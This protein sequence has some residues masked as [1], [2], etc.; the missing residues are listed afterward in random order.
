MIDSAV[1]QR[2]VKRIEGYEQAMIHLQIGL[3]AIP[4]LAPENGG[5]GGNPQGGISARL[6]AG[7]GISS[8]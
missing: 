2:I 8:C 7:P 5:D 6:P 4:A 3:T 1:F